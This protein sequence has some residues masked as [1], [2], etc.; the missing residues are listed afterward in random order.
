M[1]YCAGIL[2]LLWFCSPFRGMSQADTASRRIDAW[3]VAVRDDLPALRQF[4]NH[5]PK[6]GDIHHH[7]HGSVYAETY[8]EQAI[9]DNFWLHLPT[10][11]TA[12]PGFKPSRQERHAWHRFADL[13]ASGQLDAQRARILAQWSVLHYD[14]GQSPLNQHDHFFS[15]FHAFDAVSDS[16]LL[17][18]LLELK[19]RAIR[20]R[21]AYIESIFLPI[22]HNLRLEE[23]WNAS[24]RMAAGNPEQLFSQLSVL[25]VELTA[26][27]AFEG[28]VA[29]HNALVRDLHTRAALD[30][31][32]FTM[33]YQNFVL[34][35]K[36]PVE[37]FTDLALCFASAQAEPLIVGVN[38]V[39]PEADAVSVQDYALHMLF[40][41]FLRQRYPAVKCALH[42]GELSLGQVKPEDM[43]WH[44]DAALK[45]AGADRIGHGVA[46]PYED[47]AVLAWMR[48]ENVPVE[49]CFT[50]NHF[51][52]GIPPSE[53]P[54]SLYRRAGV[55]IIIGSDDAGV[56]RHHL[57]EEYVN[58]YRYHS[59]TYSEIKRIAFNAIRYSFLDDDRL[60]ERLLMQLE[61]DFE[62]FEATCCFGN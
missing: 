61:A 2:L 50:S 32:D 8:L 14:A 31:D 48:R 20:E 5:M 38:I 30:D 1:K 17:T 19:D 59:P 7:Y 21:I 60:R 22:R 16:S 47:P 4:F 53:H 29:Q 46:I 13:Q 28:A 39:A 10:G 42:A 36:S 58:L 11:R 44:I 49:I 26:S 54:V 51:I 33:R 55:P 45:V 34:R 24:L 15:T 57:T 25:L 56:L 35:V 18:G 62:A 9:A 23:T 6:G 37:V 40:F 3:L 41:Q 27:P 43:G 12:R 52:L